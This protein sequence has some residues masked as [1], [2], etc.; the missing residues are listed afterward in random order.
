MYDIHF[1]RFTQHPKSDTCWSLSVGPDGRIYCAACAELVPGER[2][3]L[4]RYNEE[5]DD[6]DRLLDM[7]VV[8]DDP[9]DSGR[10]T[11]CKIHDSFAPSMSDGVMYMATHLSGAPFDLKW[12]SPWHYWHDEKRCFRGAAMVAFDTRTDEVLWWDTIVPKEGCRCLL[13]DVPR[14]MFYF[15]SY[16]RD[17][18]FEYDLK[19]R[20]TRDLGRVGSVNTQ[21]IFLDRRHRVYVASDYGHLMRYDPQADRMEMS[22]FVLPHH[23]D[24]Q[25]GWHSVLYDAAAS[26][27]RDCIYASSWSGHPRLMRYWPDDGDWGK[28][29]DLGPA[30]VEYDRTLPVDTFADHCGGLTFAGDDQL[31]YVS[32][33]WDRTWDRDRPM[34]GSV[35]RLDPNTLSREVVA[36][37]KREDGQDAQYVSR[38]AVDHNG[39]LFFAHVNPVPDAIPPGIFKVTL[40]EDRKRPNAHLPIRVWG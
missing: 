26:P 28:V 34:E 5:A 2:A 9:R 15:V 6:L 20:S 35:I 18:L 27:D 31:Y 13:Y 4:F 3:V 24:I 16:P 17:H 36:I 30:T 8:V 22:P 12:Y 14:G 39:D 40:P 33:R 25:N 23:P 1:Y 11:Q 21:V 10:G 29:E 32:S 37:L 19:R 7:D 38:G